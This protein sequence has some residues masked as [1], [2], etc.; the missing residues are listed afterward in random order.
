VVDTP[1]PLAFNKAL[2]TPFAKVCKF[3]V[4]TTVR[5]ESSNVMLVI[6]KAGDV[7]SVA[8]AS[9]A[10]TAL[11]AALVSLVEALP[12]L[13]R[14]ALALAAAAVAEALASLALVVAIPA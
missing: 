2:S 11:A 9:L 12:S 1:V 4:S 6:A 14:A 10:V 13:V 5:L 8:A 3:V 7:P